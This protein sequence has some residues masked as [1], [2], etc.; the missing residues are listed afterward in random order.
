[1]AEAGIRLETPVA[2]RGA[3]LLITNTHGECGEDPL[4]G[5]YTLEVRHLRILRFE[6]N[7]ERPW[8]CE[9]SRV[10]PDELAFVFAY[11]ELV[12]FGGGGSGASGDEPTFDARG[13]P[14]RGLDVRLTYRVELDRL[15]AR[16]VVTNRSRFAVKFEAR[17][18][19]APDYAD[20]LE[21]ND[22]R[23]QQDA[24]IRA[25]VEDGRVRL[26]YDHDRLPFE[27]V[28]TSA[29]PG[30]PILGKQSSST[31]LDLPAQGEA[32]LELTVEAIDPHRPLDEKDRRAR[33]EH[34]DQWRASL[35]RISLPGNPGIQRILGQAC[36][37][38]ASFPLLEG[39]PDEWLAL[40]A[41]VPLYP[42]FFGRDALTAGWQAGLLDSGAMLD[43]ALTRLGRLQSDRV[44]DWRDEEP[45]R[46]PYQVR[47]GPLARLEKNPYAAYYA[48]F[49]SPLMYVISFA[50]LFA[51]RG[52]R[53]ELGRHW[54]TARRIL[55]WARAYGDRDGDGYL[56]YVTKSSMGTKNQGWKDSGDAIV[57]EDG[58]PVP[59][60]IAPCEVQGYWYAAQL[61]MAGLA[62]VKGERRWA[63]ELWRSAR[64]LKRRFNRDFWMEEEGF[65][66][67][68]LD[69][70]KR[71]VRA[72]TSNV[73]HCLATGI[74]DRT[75]LPKVIERLFA[76]D[77]FSGWGIR[78]LSS[79]HAAYHPL[80][81]H[82]GTVWAV[83]NATICFGLR[84]FGFE[85][86]AVRL[87]E[88]LFELASLYRGGRIPETVGGYAREDHPTPGAYPRSNTPQTWNASALPLCL[89]T[90]LGLLPYAAYHVLVVDPVLPGW[91]PA[92]ELRKLRVGRTTASLRFWRDED[93]GSHVRLLDK[94]GPLHVIRQP[95]FEALR[96]SAGRRLRAL[97]F[98]GQ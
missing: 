59:A 43:A 95:P 60:P 97:L 17:W 5:F 13:L 16:A 68:A 58:T 41:G 93:G 4:S 46:I 27:T 25:E 84:R 76:P 18:V 87:A 12:Q 66:A 81:Y 49:A 21:A 34:H 32:V 20:L 31:T 44:L 61:L 96:V 11:P 83:E 73:G 24:P 94:D 64:A 23:R 47:S 1:M 74:L 89:Q 90:L 14:H 22:D 10:R 92:V 55:D 56:E 77:M 65:Y 19:F 72:V 78:T 26:G 88:A 62:W 53:D 39:Q 48:D 35:A 29:G 37:D 8:M 71:P 91:L 9:W 6:I 70:D 38:V 36:E 28:I 3:T 54:D 52:D 15:R 79:R 51:W 45:G 30:P 63:R 50:N 2:W 80:S 57:Y 98:G 82:L 86:E 67:L 42:A 69:P 40:Q 7:Q 75:R 85:A 33:M